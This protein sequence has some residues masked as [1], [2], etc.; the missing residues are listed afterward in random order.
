M[1][2][3]RGC[4]AQA[5]LEQALRYKPDFVL[6]MH[7]LATV[8]LREEQFAD[9]EKLIDAALATAANET[10]RV[11]QNVS[12]ELLADLHYSRAGVVKLLHADAG[13]TVSSL[14][15][16]L[17]LNPQHERAK[18]TLVTAML[19]TRFTKGSAPPTKSV[20]RGKAPGRRP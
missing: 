3:R 17:S 16:A 20:T 8:M 1:T 14:K 4:R 13:A 18:K 12:D 9:A 15:Q 10:L 19:Q 7:H 6:A 5:L 11:R 2:H